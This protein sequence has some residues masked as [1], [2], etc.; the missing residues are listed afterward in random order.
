MP[1]NRI[2]GRKELIRRRVHDLVSV[3]GYAGADF[4]VEFVVVSGKRV[5]IRRTAMEKGRRDVHVFWE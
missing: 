2:E 5:S 3:D 1:Q 4:A